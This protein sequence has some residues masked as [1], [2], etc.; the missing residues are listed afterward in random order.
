VTIPGSGLVT[1][2]LAGARRVEAL[3][4]EPLRV[5]ALRELLFARDED[6]RRVLVAGIP[7]R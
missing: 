7:R 5:E 1:F 6:P 2:F 4:V 3:R